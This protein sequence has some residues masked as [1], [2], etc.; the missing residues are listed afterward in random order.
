MAKYK[1][2]YRSESHRLQGWDYSREAIYFITFCVQDFECLFGDVIVDV[3]RRAY[4]KNNEI[5]NNV[6]THRRVSEKETHDGASVRVY[7]ESA[8]M[9]LNQFGQIVEDEIQKSIEI[10]KNWIFHEWVVMPNHVHML[11]EI[12]LND[13]NI[14][15][16]HSRAYQNNNEIHNN[17]IHDGKSLHRQPNSISSFIGIFKTV[18]TKQINELRNT[19]GERIWQRNYHD[20]IVRNYASFEKIGNYIEQ[21]P[22][23]WYEDRFNPIKP[24]LTKK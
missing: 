13:N 2:K 15:D 10:R 18:V 6:D 21:N 22:Q 19:K 24:N 14:V 11:I 16:T 23:R 7:D 8:R 3:H 4:P 5:Q 1:G 9:N 20:H 17:T 12:E